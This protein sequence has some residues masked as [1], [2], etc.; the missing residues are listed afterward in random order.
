MAATSIRLRLVAL[1]ILVLATGLSAA[2]QAQSA[3]SESATVSQS[4]TG[5][6]VHGHW[7]MTIRDEDGS[8]ASRNEFE[9]AIG[10]SGPSFLAGILGRTRTPGAWQIGLLGGV[11][12]NT[13]GLSVACA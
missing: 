13:E 6:K 8:V 7:I 5:I 2:T 10:T 9:N 12:K 11:C 3:Q 1:L 4:Q